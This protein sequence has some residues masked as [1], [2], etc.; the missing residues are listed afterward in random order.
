MKSN[1]LHRFLVSLL[2]VCSLLTTV[3]VPSVV[4]QSV[5]TSY[6]YSTA[7]LI[8]TVYTPIS[9]SSQVWTPAQFDLTPGDY[10]P[11]TGSFSLSFTVDSGGNGFYQNY[12]YPCLFYDYFLLSAKSGHTIRFEIQ[13]SMVERAID[14]L[15]LTP[16]QFWEFEHSNCGWGLKSSILQGMVS[17][18]VVDWPV[19]A[20]GQYAVVFATPIFYGGQIRCSA[21]DFFPTSQTQTVA[22]TVTSI[23]EITE[24]V[25]S[26]QIS[27]QSITTPY[28]SE[29]PSLSWVAVIVVVIV[30]LVFGLVMV[31]RKRR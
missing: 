12:G 31:L 28:S 15:I 30:G 5:V 8:S 20:T 21:Q 14:L 3:T 17:V 9:T 26:T 1:Q 18:S 23:Y 29:S 25:L 6:Q 27:T 24:T 10:D 13:L 2:V 4:G 16:S 7:S 19:P 22:S 11:R